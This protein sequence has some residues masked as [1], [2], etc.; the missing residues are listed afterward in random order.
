MRR[1]INSKYIAVLIVMIFGVVPLIS[2]TI[3]ILI[4][5][6]MDS[7]MNR[8]VDVISRNNINVLEVEGSKTSSGMLYVQNAWYSTNVIKLQVTPADMII[9]GDTLRV[10]FD[11]TSAVYQGAIMLGEL[12][13]VY[14]NGVCT[15]LKDH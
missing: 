5:D 13:M 15:E 2:L 8:V 14:R 4:K 9:Y 6:S 3:N 11:D 7:D 1:K 10:V 12:D